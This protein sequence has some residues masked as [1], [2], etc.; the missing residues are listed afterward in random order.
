MREK[1]YRVQ[2]TELQQQL[3]VRI[4]DDSDS[5]DGKDARGKKPKGPAAAATKFMPSIHGLVKKF[6]DS[7]KNVGPKVE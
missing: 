3:K 5:D 1:D 2:I 4:M 7:I 6:E